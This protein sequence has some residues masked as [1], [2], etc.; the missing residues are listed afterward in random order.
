[1]LSK[2]TGISAPVKNVT[3]GTRRSAFSREPHLTGTTR[4]FDYIA[5]LGVGS[6]PRHDGKPLRDGLHAPV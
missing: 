6:D 2:K 5:G 4:S 1:M 3:T